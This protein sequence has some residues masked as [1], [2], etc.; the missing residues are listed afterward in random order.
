MPRILSDE[1]R[2]RKYEMQRQWRRNKETLKTAAD[3]NDHIDGWKFRI[4]YDPIPERD[5]GFTPGAKIDK[6][7]IKL[8][9][10]LGSIVP[11]TIVEN[12]D[13]GKRLIVKKSRIRELSL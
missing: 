7:S 2:K 9:A 10:R 6:E 11:G 1:Q 12:I 8:M 13:N 3:L 5:G 4:I